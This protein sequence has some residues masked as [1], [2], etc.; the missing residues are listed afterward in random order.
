MTLIIVNLGVIYDIFMIQSIF[1]LWG[2]EWSITFDH[3]VNGKIVSNSLRGV[4]RHPLW[5]IYDKFLAY[6]KI[7]TFLHTWS[8]IFDRTVNSKIVHNSSGEVNRDP[9]CRTYGQLQSQKIP[10]SLSR[11]I[12]WVVLK[13][14]NPPK[15]KPKSPPTATSYLDSVSI[16][17]RQPEN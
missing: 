13:L 9:T 17:V 1:F 12:D 16:S 10:P 11:N 14:Q 15:K 7:L 5:H 8:I 6:W 3:I 2:R 4:S